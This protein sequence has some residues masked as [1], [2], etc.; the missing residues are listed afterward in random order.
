MTTY[1]VFDAEDSGIAR[2]GLSLLDAMDEMLTYDGYEYEIR[3]DAPGWGLWHSQ[4]S[5]NSPRGLGQMV[6][7]NGTYVLA[8][9]ARDARN[10]I[11]EMVVSGRCGWSH[12][13]REAMTDEDFAAMQARIAA[14]IAESEG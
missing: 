3:S 2:R 14:E 1:T 13:R 12:K 9:D 8:S 5:R 10:Q 7:C 4:G 6:R 11:A